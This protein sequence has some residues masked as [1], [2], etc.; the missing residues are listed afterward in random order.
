MWQ[1]PQNGPVRCG[2][3]KTNPDVWCSVLDFR[4]EIGFNKMNS[5]GPVAVDVCLKPALIAT[6]YKERIFVGFFSSFF[7][8]LFFFFGSPPE[9]A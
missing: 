5:R 3:I 2:P 6:I 4:A 9:R 1:A 8:F 7:S